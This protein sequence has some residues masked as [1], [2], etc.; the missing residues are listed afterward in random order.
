MPSRRTPTSAQ[1]RTRSGRADGP[2]VKFAKVVIVT[3]P[4]FRRQLVGRWRAGSARRKRRGP[5]A[6][7][8]AV[9][10][11]SRRRSGLTP[12][13]GPQ[14]GT[15]A[16]GPSTAA[17]RPGH[18]REPPSSV[19]GTR[20]GRDIGPRHARRPVGSRPALLPASEAVRP[21]AVRPGNTSCRS[22]TTFA[23][24]AGRRTARFCT[25]PPENGRLG[26]RAHS[27]PPF[28]GT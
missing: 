22:R 24:R 14:A 1:A 5:V 20:L 2:A 19:G 23:M 8:R 18:P 3:V 4:L 28:A 16:S 7:W 10:G 12:S 9:A 27:S 13:P 21:T 15:A 25:Q 6:H 26:R 17:F 11:W